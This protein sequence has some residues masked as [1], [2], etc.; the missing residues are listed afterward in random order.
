MSKT[1]TE[2]LKRKANQDDS[3]ILTSLALTINLIFYLFY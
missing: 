3:F 1:T 2:I